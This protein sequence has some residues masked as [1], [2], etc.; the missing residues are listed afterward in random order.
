[1]YKRQVL[2]KLTNGK[3]GI[4]VFNNSALGAEKD[5]IEQ[6]KIGAIAMTR[7]NIAPMNNICPA[8]VVPTMP[9]LF[10]SKEHML[11][12]LDGPVGEEILRSCEAQ[13]FIGLAYYD[14]GSRSIYTV[15]KPVKTLADMKGLKVRVQQSDL[16]A[17]SYTHLTLPT[18]RIV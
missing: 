5:T 6:T 7:V 17:V 9:F 13:G 3:H 15:K 18:K 14:S 8:T 12:V 1:M 2:N 16:W 11:H 4:K 10:N